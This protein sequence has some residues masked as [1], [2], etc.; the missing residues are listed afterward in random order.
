MNKRSRRK[1]DVRLVAERPSVRPRLA[2]RDCFADEIAIDFPSLRD[3][4][5]RMRE[6]F[7]PPDCARRLSARLLLTPREAFDGVTVPLDLPI[8]RMCTSCGGRGEVWTEPCPECAGSG[9]AVVPQPINLIVPPGVADGS[10]F[11]LSV[12]MP[13]ASPTHLEVSVEIR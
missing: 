2:R 3:T 10:R 9:G 7:V 6:A 11:S 8:L 12:S 1:H 5:D 4:I 13:S